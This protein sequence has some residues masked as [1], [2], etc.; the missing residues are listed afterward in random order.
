MEDKELDLLVQTHA[1]QAGLTPKQARQALKKLREGGMMAQIAPQLTKKLTD[2]NP[3]LSPRE[4]L[5]NKIKESK[6]SRCIK[7]V[8]VA[9]YERQKKET[10]DRE[11]KMEDEKAKKA[12]AILK[13]KRAHALKLK[14]LNKK[15]GIISEDKYM[16][17]LARQRDNVYKHESDMNYD[18]NIID[19]YAMQKSFTQSINMADLDD[20]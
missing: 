7:E 14:E 8:K 15:L 2:I 20:F 9:Q 4:K 17:C 10:H 16:D 18:K 12:E 19:L 3:N 6:Q 11:V 13:K 1:K 5:L